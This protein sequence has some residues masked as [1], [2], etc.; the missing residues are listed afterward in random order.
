MAA[1]MPTL[2]AWLPRK[3]A[4]PFKADSRG[5]MEGKIECSRASQS[6]SDGRDCLPAHALFKMSAVS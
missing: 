2:R 3:A 4:L 6:S 1:V 5:A